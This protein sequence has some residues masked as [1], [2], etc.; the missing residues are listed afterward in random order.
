MEKTRINEYV[1]YLS[2]NENV[3]QRYILFINI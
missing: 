3:E 2:Y 1:T